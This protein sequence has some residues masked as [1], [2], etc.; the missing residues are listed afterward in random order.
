[1]KR[2]ALA[3]AV[4]GV[5]H[6]HGA[7]AQSTTVELTESAGYS[8]DRVA[9]VATQVR[10]FG[11]TAAG[12]R[13]NVEAAWAAR[14]ADD[15]DAF[16]AA[17]PYTDRVQMIE[18][19][20]ERISEPGHGL[21]GVKLGRYRTPFGISSG[22]DYAYGGFLRAPLIRYP[23]YFALSNNFLEQ[24]ADVIVGTPRLSL[25]GSAGIPGDVGTATR[26]SGLDTVWR[27]QGTLPALIV[28][29]SYIETRPYQPAI[30]AQGRTKFA[31]V[32]VRWMRN[33]VQL[34]G[35]WIAG[36]PF[37]G[38]STTGGYVD[39]IVHRP[40]FGPVTTVF[41]AERLTYDAVAPFAMAVQ[42]Y[43]A[44]GRIRLFHGLE[45]DVDLVRQTAQLPEGRPT[46]AD[47]GLT[48]SL[49]RH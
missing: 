17:Y 42:R 46:S 38:T 32:D 7:R 39:V 4:F 37:D 8:T 33:G 47:I 24:G 41:R 2:F 5:V 35:E 30:F 43:T 22:S 26:P 13:F 21:F 49:R 28:G 19:Y 45:A 6:A 31:G 44:G 10:G 23:N 14:S 15:S 40:G 3:L 9:A 27:A 48:Y 20:A 29:V 25:E 12:V 1:M 34:R 18:A 11:E 16:G 36:R